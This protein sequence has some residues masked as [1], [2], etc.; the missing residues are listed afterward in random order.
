MEN[1]RD[2]LSIISNNNHITY[3]LLA[4]KQIHADLGSAIEKISKEHAFQQALLENAPLIILSTNNDGV[5]T[6]MNR[7]GENL[8]GY[9]KEEVV[10]L[11][12]PLTF[13][14][15]QEL[16]QIRS[17]RRWLEAGT[18]EV[19]FVSKEGKE[20]I[21]EI[22]ISPIWIEGKIS[23]Y[24]MIGQDITDRKLKELELQQKNEELT[25]TEEEL[26]QNLE[27]MEATQEEL[28]RNQLELQG[29]MNA[30][31][32]AALVSE[33]DIRGNITF[34]NETFAKIS[35][36]T[37]EELLGK[38]HRILKSGKQDDAI[39]V[40]M[41]ATISAGKVWRGIICNKKKN[42]EFYWVKSTI[43]PVL[44]NQGIP[45]K[46]I[47]VRFE[48]TEEKELEE[49][50]SKEIKRNFSQLIQNEKMAALGQ[51]VAG[52]AHEINTPIG[53]INAAAVN[54]QDNFLNIIQL[55]IKNI[56]IIET[57]PELFQEICVYLAQSKETLSSREE[58][59][60]K[61]KLLNILEEN[62][63]PNADD[64]ATELAAIAFQ[65]DIV[66]YL[67]LLKLQNAEFE[68]LL[69]SIG[70]TSINTSSI[71]EAV[72]KTQKI[73][74]ALKS[75]TYRRNYEQKEEVNI[76]ET[77]DNILTLY[78][79]QTK[80]N[81]EVITEYQELPPIKAYADEIGQVWNNIIVNALQ[82]MKFQ[83]KL[84]I[85]TYS[86]L[87]KIVVQII[88]NGPGIP[89]EIQDKIF[90]PFFTTKPQGEG[91]GL[92]LDICKK[93]IEEK[94]HG[95]IE[96]FSEPGCTCFRI[97]LPLEQSEVI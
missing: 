89:K 25:A 80:H 26:R 17:F 58:R 35:G 34:A 61:K 45:V 10:N 19:N 22:S 96:V 38:N 90:E 27:E 63:I 64:I 53:A 42:G 29:Q 43:T 82:A 54:I 66:P 9:S 68:Q 85:Q 5:I 50:L 3:E 67:V 69:Y 75:Y 91:T 74:S 13:L 65:I 78:H 6:Y 30:L 21:C 79:N 93:I 77:I 88:D 51:L 59:Q 8:L 12:T 1:L 83:G 71:Q 37:V 76:N 73:I 39:F 14:H 15:A 46:Y 41:W 56:A 40:D 33:T 2:N 60:L 57:Y 72:R 86:E 47:G 97:I 36:Y 7:F 48:I 84:I 32:N 44:D 18:H 94:H 52:V 55:F 16:A 24:L 49:K 87:D 70:K 4:I 92:G 23:G 31:H 20:F 28:L 11:S 62:N 81:V 95:K